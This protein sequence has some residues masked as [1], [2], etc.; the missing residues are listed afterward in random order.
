MFSAVAAV[1]A[2][3]DAGAYANL[4]PIDPQSASSCARLAVPRCDAGLR[5]AEA[6]PPNCI[7]LDGCPL[8]GCAGRPRPVG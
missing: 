7:L 3:I 8:D 4:A 1:G 2:F 5:V 6:R